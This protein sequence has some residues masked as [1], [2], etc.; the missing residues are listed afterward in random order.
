MSSKIVHMNSEP[1]SHATSAYTSSMSPSNSFP[2]N[3][4][5]V[6]QYNALVSRLDEALHARA[7][8]EG[9]LEAMHQHAA[10]LEHR[11]AQVMRVPP[12]TPSATPMKTYP[13]NTPAALSDV[14]AIA[15]VPP[16]TSRARPEKE[17]LSHCSDISNGV[18]RTEFL[19]SGMPPVPTPPAPSS[20]AC[21]LTVAASANKE[22]SGLSG[23]V[24]KTKSKQERPIKVKI[25]GQSRYWTPAE[26]KLFLEAFQKFGHKDLR[27]ISAHVGTRNMTQVRTHSQKYFMRLMRE[28]KRQNPSS[29]SDPETAA[30]TGAEEGVSPNDAKP[31]GPTEV[32]G[33]NEEG[34]KYS[35]P[36]TCGMTLLCLVGED[37]LPM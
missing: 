6:E 30:K 5:S 21:P 25:P 8:L 1:N 13:A 32:N 35:V 11:L 18:R 26:H 15:P 4:V 36:S 7:Q 9:Q 28:A 27:S 24:K 16:C 29:H 23:G 10:C 20:A 19:V 31:A 12:Q 3:T 17:V 33:K 34:G 2:S 22:T 14:D 37:T